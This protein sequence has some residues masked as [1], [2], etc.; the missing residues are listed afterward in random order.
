MTFPVNSSFLSDCHT[1]QI[2]HSLL[3]S[4]LGGFVG[5][6]LSS[7]FY[8]LFLYFCLFVLLSLFLCISYFQFLHVL[9]F[10]IS[11]CLCFTVSLSCWLYIF[12]LYY[13]LLVFLSLFLSI[14][15]F[16]SGIFFLSVFLDVYVSFYISFFLSLFLPVSHSLF[17][18]VAHCP[19]FSYHVFFLYLLLT[20]SVFPCFFD[21]SQSN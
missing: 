4:F 8:F 18:Y 9:S 10:C 21:F 6:S 13:Y 3:Y 15:Y 5:V 16:H 19:I 2:S 20:L 17:R 7:C 1:F 12:F 11:C 14:S